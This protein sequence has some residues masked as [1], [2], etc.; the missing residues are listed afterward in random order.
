MRRWFAL[1]S[2]GRARFYWAVG[3]LFMVSSGARYSGSSIAMV[4]VVGLLWGL[5]WPAVKIMIAEI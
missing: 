2:V 3:S 5:N 4:L 1:G